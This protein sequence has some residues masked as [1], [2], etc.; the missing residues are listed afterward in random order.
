[1]DPLELIHEYGLLAVFVAVFLEQFGLPIP[2]LPLLLIAGA[3]AVGD[4]WFGVTAWILAMTASLAGGTVLFLGG[5]SWATRYCV[6]CAACP[7]RRMP[8]SI[9]AVPRSSASGPRR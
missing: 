3:A 2:A 8:V 7:C 1:M 9:T 4:P 6:S 5:R